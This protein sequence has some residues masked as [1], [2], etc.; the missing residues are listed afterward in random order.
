MTHCALREPRKDIVVKLKTLRL[1]VNNALGVR[2]QTA[3]R[4]DTEKA[5]RRPKCLCIN[6]AH[7]TRSKKTGFGHA[8]MLS[9]RA[10]DSLSFGDAISHSARWATG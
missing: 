10:R 5:N 7:H 8:C 2:A 4:S 1:S 9:V 3:K 6:V